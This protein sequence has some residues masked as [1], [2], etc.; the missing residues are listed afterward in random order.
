MILNVTP[1][2]QDHI[3]SMLNRAGKTSV[4]LGLEQ[5]GCNGYK[6][7]WTPVDSDSGDN[8]IALN[9]DYLIIVSNKVL[10]Y[11]IDSTISMEVNDFNRK[12]VLVNP[13]EASACG[14]GES[15]NF[16]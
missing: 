16:K 4:E 12:L 8:V 10:P 3:I 6:Y 7:T 15:I 2:A 5:Q 1:E 13:H 9:E 11:V 14:C